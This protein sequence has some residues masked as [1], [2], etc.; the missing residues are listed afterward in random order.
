MKYSYLESVQF[1]VNNNRKYQ[2]EAERDQLRGTPNGAEQLST[3]VQLNAAEPNQT[4][5]LK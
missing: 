4:P 3:H 5:G 2:A 1:H